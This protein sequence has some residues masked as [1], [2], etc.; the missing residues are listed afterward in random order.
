MD[1]GEI[2]PNRYIGHTPKLSRYQFREPFILALSF[3]SRKTPSIGSSTILPRNI[4]KL[5]DPFE[6]G[7][8]LPSAQ[9]STTGPM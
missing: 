8:T 6:G 7:F 2:E 9:L 3:V 5:S 1:V 4:Y